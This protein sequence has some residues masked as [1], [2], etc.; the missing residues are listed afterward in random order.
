MVVVEIV[1]AVVLEIVVT[2][3]TIA[4]LNF[5]SVVEVSVY[6]CQVLYPG[7]V[8]LFSVLEE[9]VFLIVVPILVSVPVGVRVNRVSGGASF[10]S[11]DDLLYSAGLSVAPSGFVAL[12]GGFIDE[13]LCCTV[14]H[15]GDDVVLFVVLFPVSA[16][17]F[18]CVLVKC[19][20]L[21]Y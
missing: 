20:R 18:E 6:L 16:D 19:E 5:R 8:A 12:V 9:G 3:C 13:G 21:C 2:V 17:P 1:D 7:L 4:D 14:V 15:V 10:D 11:V